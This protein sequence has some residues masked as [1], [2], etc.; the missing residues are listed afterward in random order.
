[1]LVGLTTLSLCS[2]GI[3]FAQPS[4]ATAS[5]M[6]STGPTVPD[7]RP[8]DQSRLDTSAGIPANTSTNGAV[9]HMSSNAETT[10]NPADKP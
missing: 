3:A 5:A 6:G 7:T 10:N 8:V 2:G 9:V 4:T 1:M